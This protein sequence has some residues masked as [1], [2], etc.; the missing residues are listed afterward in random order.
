M[1]DT[2][3]KYIIASDS[4]VKDWA[5]TYKE[6][7]KWF[8]V[9]RDNGRYT[10][11]KGRRALHKIIDILEDANKKNRVHNSKMARQALKEMAEKLYGVDWE[12]K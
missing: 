12:H 10:H 1:N 7:E 11:Y 4:Q 3:R 6:V 8:E 9:N 2:E 5:M